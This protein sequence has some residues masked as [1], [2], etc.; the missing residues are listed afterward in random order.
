M[1]PVWVTRIGREPKSRS[2][3]LT[4]TASITGSQTASTRAQPEM[5][6]T[7]LASAFVYAL[8]WLGSSSSSGFR[9]SR[10][11]F[12]SSRVLS[13]E[14]ETMPSWLQTPTPWRCWDGRT[15]RKSRMTGRS[16][17]GSCQSFS[18]VTLST[19]QVIYRVSCSSEQALSMVFLFG[20]LSSYTWSLVSAATCFHAAST[21]SPLESEPQLP[22]SDWL[23]SRF[24]ISLPT[25]SS[26]EGR[27][28]GKEY[29]WSPS[30]PF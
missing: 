25:G 22:F 4:L 6:T 23:V 1:T 8:L 21:Q 17:D 24:S 3:I 16:G 18:T 10:S 13:M 30:L 14:F 9:S 7:V 28:S 27:T 26:W 19:W 15:L 5:R 20:L 12:S 11:C 29:S 2:K